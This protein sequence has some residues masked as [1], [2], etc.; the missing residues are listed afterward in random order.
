MKIAHL[1]YTMTVGGIETMLV[2]IL[3]EQ[4]KHIDVF[5]VII[6]QQVEDSI[7]SGID[8]RVKIIKIGR[9]IGNKSPWYLLKLNYILWKR[10]FDLIHVHH[11]G[12]ARFLYLP[13]VKNKLCFTMHHIAISNDV[14][15]LKYYKHI[16]AISKTVYENL[17]SYGYQSNVVMNGIIS[18]LFLSKKENHNSNKFNIVQVGRLS[19]TEKGQDVL[20]R[21]CVQLQKR[22]ITNFHLDF[23]GSGP[24]EAY[25]Q[26]I[27]E[28]NGLQ[29]DISFLGNKSQEYMH[30]HLKDYS[31]FV[32]P[33][34]YEGFG[35]T[36]VEA[37]AAQIPIL[38]S[39]QQGP[40]EII[41][42]GEFGFYFETDN[43]NDCAEKI[44]Q[45]MN[46]KTL[47][48]LTKKAYNRVRELYDVK[49]TAEEYIN[50]Y[51]R[52]IANKA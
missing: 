36:V 19:H 45:I 33:S 11:P 18:D 8:K 31:L 50:Y 46:L 13:F 44:V 14:S 10:S 35:L 52:I 49:R 39:N 51:K 42:D 28:K 26:E 24:S 30:A 27:V 37:M 5:L 22:G 34:R 29:N 16:F 41:D 48:I 20:I 3:N 25:L 43:V 40:M 9:P 38:V 47:D 21:A 7:L 17:L 6:N 23:I 15:F 2:N 1:T 12:I 4:V 32:Q